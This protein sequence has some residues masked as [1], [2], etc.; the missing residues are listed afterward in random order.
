MCSFNIPDLIGFLTFLII[1]VLFVACIIWL[2][3]TKR[4]ERWTI[5]LILSGFL[6]VLFLF[7][8]IIL[9][10]QCI[11]SI[12]DSL[13]N[14]L[15]YADYK[16]SF[17]ESV[18]GM[19]GTV[20]AIFGALWADNELNQKQR[21]EEDRRQEKEQKQQDAVNARI[22][23]YDF[24]FVFQQ[25]K[26]KYESASTETDDNLK[27]EAFHRSIIN[28][29]ILI[30]DQWIRT[31]AV[32]PEDPFDHT[33]RHHIYSLYDRIC[34]IRTAIENCQEGYVKSKVDKAYSGVKELLEIAPNAHRIVPTNP[35]NETIARQNM[36][37]NVWSDL[38]ATA[39]I[40]QSSQ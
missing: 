17:I 6:C 37:D 22:I 1:I 16:S 26:E 33:K 13:L 19:L 25:M 14:G 40:N 2:I 5:F 8:P 38:I 27:K 34:S 29:R 28:H 15:R 31:V 3:I 9:Q 12:V 4:K 30:D 24:L 7:M 18:G 35:D 39:R 20:L 32:L 23:Y 21:K 10:N 11:A 36:S